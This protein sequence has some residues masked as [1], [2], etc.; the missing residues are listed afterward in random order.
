MEIFGFHDMYLSLAHIPYE[1]WTTFWVQNSK[2][3]TFIQAVPGTFINSSFQ[4]LNEFWII[5]LL[6]RALVSLMETVLCIVHFG[7]YGE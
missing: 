5:G 7:P 2:V 1:G 3:L 6:P 4:P